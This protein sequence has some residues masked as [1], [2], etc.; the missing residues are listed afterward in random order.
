MKT[1]RKIL[2]DGFVEVNMNLEHFEF[3]EKG[4]TRL[5]YD[6]V[7]KEIVVIY[8]VKDVWKDVY[9]LLENIK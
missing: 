7:K 2:N 1:L 6:K 9:K 5:L 3:Y 4:D 8:N